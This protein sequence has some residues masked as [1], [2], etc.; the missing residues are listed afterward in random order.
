MQ[1]S[2]KTPDIIVMCYKVRKSFVLLMQDFERT[3]YRVLLFFFFFADHAG[4]RWGPMEVLFNIYIRC[5]VR[6]RETGEGC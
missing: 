2:G 1:E 4:F 5:D 6:E 3:I